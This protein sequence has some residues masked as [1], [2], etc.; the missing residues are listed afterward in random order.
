MKNIIKWQNLR[1]EKKKEKKKKKK[2]KK[3]EI[4]WNCWRR[5]E[6]SYVTPSE[7]MGMETFGER[8]LDI[9]FRISSGDKGRLFK[10]ESRQVGDFCFLFIRTR[11]GQVDV[12]NRERTE[13]HKLKIRASVRSVDG[14]D[15]DLPSAEAS[16]WVHVLDTND[17]SPLFYPVFFLFFFLNSISFY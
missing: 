1:I 9:R 16:V 13:L 6:Q 15:D 14:V 4:E 10:A 17:L 12:L 2:R 7:R 5:F 8:R 3:K 11:T